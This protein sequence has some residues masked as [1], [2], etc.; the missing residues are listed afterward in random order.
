M[1][2]HASHDERNTYTGG[3]AGDQYG[4]EVVI[5]TW[6][7]RPWNVVLRCKDAGKREL[8]A[9]AMEQACANNHIGYDQNQRTTLFTQASKVGFDLSK[10]TVDCETDCSALVSVCVNAAGIY[11]SKDIYT[12]N[13]RQ[14]L[15]NTGWFE[16]LT[17]SKYLTSDKYL[18]RGDILLYEN[19]HTAVNLTDGELIHRYEPNKWYRDANGW[20]YSTSE[21]TYA[22]SE[23]LDINHH[24]YYFNDKGYAVTGYQNIDGGRYYFETSGDLECALMITN[25]ADQLTYKYII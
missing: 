2:G 16:A 25:P 1:I 20:W 4:T 21:N 3:K 24:R 15:L 19:H 10:I 22:K 13:E 14:A 11:V 7:N 18:Y 23:W 6:Y 9:R 17:D 5:R 12:G 8:I